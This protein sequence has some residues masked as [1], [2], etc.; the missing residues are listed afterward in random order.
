[1]RKF[2]P[3]ITFDGK[4]YKARSHK[5]DV[6]NFAE[7]SRMEALIWLN[8]NTYAQGRSTRPNNPL[9]GFGGALSITAV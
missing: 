9:A 8:R 2:K 7:M 3:F 6:P 5:V 4:V 1:M